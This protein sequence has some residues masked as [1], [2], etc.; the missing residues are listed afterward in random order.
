MQESE[1]TEII[2]FTCSSA[3]WGQYL[4]LSQSELSRGSLVGVVMV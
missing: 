1:F 3:L 2:P 4:V